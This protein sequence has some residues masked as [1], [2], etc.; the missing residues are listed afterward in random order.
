MS[1]SVWKSNS[2][3]VRKKEQWFC[4]RSE[5]D[6]GNYMYRYAC[7]RCNYPRHGLVLPL[8]NS[9]AGDWYCLTEKCYELNF[10]TRQNCRQCG[11][12]KN[13]IRHYECR[14]LLECTNK[15]S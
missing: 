6:S 9:N 15:L 3:C 8:V 5:C 2:L 11:C 12:P 4:T 1:V 10:G 13:K 7:R 14:N